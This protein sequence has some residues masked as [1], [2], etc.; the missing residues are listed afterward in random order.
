MAETTRPDPYAV[1]GVPRDA[2]EDEVRAA[3]R[4]LVRSEHPDK[5]GSHERFIMVSWAYEMLTALEGY[6]TLD[7]AGAASDGTEPN[8][9]AYEPE[10]DL[11]PSH[12]VLSCT[13]LDFGTVSAGGSSR[14]LRFDVFYEADPPEV[15]YQP[16]VG[17]W[18]TTDALAVDDPR[19]AIQIEVIVAA[20]ADSPSGDLCDR[21]VV[22]FDDAN[23][24]AI[25]IRGKIV[26][27]PVTAER[28][29]PP[30][31]GPGDAARAGAHMAKP[32][33]SPGW[34]P[35]PPLPR[36][37][38]NPTLGRRIAMSVIWPL[39]GLSCVALVFAL[40]FGYAIPTSEL[41]NILWLQFLA[42]PVCALLLG[43]AVFVILPWSLVHAV[44]QWPPKAERVRAAR[45]Y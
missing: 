38:R 6:A 3:Y 13:V 43:V 21:I 25:E 9:G 10:Q 18:W 30:A 4:R 5:G 11:G 22:T 28:R 17:L 35:R 23:S 12:P 14:V 2:S 8:W 7:F 16:R 19:V 1:L 33:A 42:I 40:T 39:F 34:R 37:R 15:D 36:D 41:P 29:N 32:A 44:R 26:G 45:P 20:P 27:K 24:S 31:G